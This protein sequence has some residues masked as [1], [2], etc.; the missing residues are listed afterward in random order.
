LRVAAN[1][2]DIHAMIRRTQTIAGREYWPL[3]TQIDH[4]HLAGQ[5]AAAWADLPFDR[6]AAGE[7]IEAVF[8]HDDGWAEWDAQPGVDP[9]K[10]RPRQYTEMPLDESLAIWRKSIDTVERIGPLAAFAVSGH[11]SGL[12]RHTNR[13]QKTPGSEDGAAHAFL[14]EQDRRRKSWLDAWLAADA[15]HTREQAQLAIEMLQFF[16]A[17]SLWLCCA[18]R[19]EPHRMTSP[20]GVALTFTPQ[21]VA[22]AEQAIVVEPWPLTTNDLKLD[23]DARAVAAVEYTSRDELSAAPSTMIRL[24][25]RLQNL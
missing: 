14:D 16:D 11:F 2:Y 17:L 21:A 6:A 8:H 13:W 22:P 18:E 1:Q 4:A 19:S 7:L 24:A 10:R 3:I 15:R 5:I 25:W 12:I 9:A 23:V 20:T